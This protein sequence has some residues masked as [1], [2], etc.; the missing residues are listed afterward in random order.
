M[1]ETG[2]LHEPLSEDEV[3]DKPWLHPC[4]DAEILKDLASVI[5]DKQLMKNVGYYLNFRYKFV[6]L[7]FDILYNL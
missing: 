4:R 3:R 7:F 5:L 6:N 2:C 1:I